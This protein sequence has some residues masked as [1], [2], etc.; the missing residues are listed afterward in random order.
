MALDD[1]DR[2]LRCADE[3]TPAAHCQSYFLAADL[4]GVFLPLFLLGSFGR[5]LPN[6]PRY[7]LPRRVLR[8]PLP[9]WLYSC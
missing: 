9:T 5:L 6:E 8:S 2:M 3:L 7:I 1:L 4:L